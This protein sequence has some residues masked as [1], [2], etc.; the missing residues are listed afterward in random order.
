MLCCVLHAVY[1]NPRAMSEP[2]PTYCTSRCLFY[3]QAG[4]SE[5]DA[6]ADGAAR[7]TAGCHAARQFTDTAKFTLR[8][9]VCALGLV[10][11][12]EA[13][14]HAKATGHQNFAEY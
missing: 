14:E 11:E 3:M 1:P 9:G 2:S 10:G 13:V 12:K 6:A 4:S 5:A 7:L 8:C